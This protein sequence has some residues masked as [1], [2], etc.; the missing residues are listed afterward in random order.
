MG[1]LM[2]DDEFRYNSTGLTGPASKAAAI[3][4]SDTVDL[5]SVPRALYCTGEGTVRVT[6][7]LGGDPVDLP[8]LVGIPLPVRVTR[9]WDSGTD[10]TGIVGVW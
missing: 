5:T 9:V 2:P 3:T 10:A 6:M 4:P 7:R 1:V 8:M